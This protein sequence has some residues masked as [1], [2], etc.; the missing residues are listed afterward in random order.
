MFVQGMHSFANKHFL[1]VRGKPSNGLLCGRHEISPDVRVILAPCCVHA[2]R[3]PCE[4]VF[5]VVP[6]EP[7]SSNWATDLIQCCQLLANFWYFWSIW[8]I[9]VG[10]PLSQLYAAMMLNQCIISWS[11]NSGRIRRA[12]CQLQPGIHPRMS[13]GC[14]HC[15]CSNA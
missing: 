14:P 8:S 5:T 4:A 2:C 15:R 3:V 7:Q 12:L 6:G 13:T 9:A 10:E 11:E 1:P